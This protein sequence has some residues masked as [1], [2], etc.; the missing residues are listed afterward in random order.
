MRPCPACGGYS[1]RQLAPSFYEC[2]CLL[3]HIHRTPMYAL[4]VAT[5]GEHYMD[6]EHYLDNLGSAPLPGLSRLLGIPL[7]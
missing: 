2:T 6:N 4:G 1:R 3:D 7:V 5:C